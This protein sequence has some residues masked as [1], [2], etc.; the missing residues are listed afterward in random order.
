MQPAISI[1]VCH[2]DAALLSDFRTN[3]D[4]S[5]GVP[6]EL[7]V[8]DNTEN[9]YSIFG[10]YNEGVK[11][12]NGY[13][14]C[15]AHEDIAFHTQGWGHRVL[16]HFR[17]EKIGMIGVVG[18]DGFPKSPSWWWNTQFGNNHFAYLIQHWRT[19]KPKQTY[20][21]PVE[22]EPHKTVMFNNPQNALRSRVVCLD[23]LWF[24][25]RKQLFESQVRFDDDYY[26]GFHCYDTDISLQ[27]GRLKE[28]YVV[29]DIL[30]EH[31]SDANANK[32]FFDSCFLHFMKWKDKLPVSLKL[33]NDPKL[34][35]AY[36]YK[37]MLDYFYALRSCK[38]YQD[39]EIKQR[40][41]KVLFQTKPSPAIL[42]FQIL[43]WWGLLGYE[44]AR[45]PNFLIRK[46]LNPWLI[47]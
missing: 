32:E 8:I 23:G 40:I 5:I 13:I 42:E 9:R 31:F 18:G 21:Q 28:V 46:T 24:C 14:L 37:A 41:R 12:S 19:K 25:I 34:L 15:F 17:E 44:L 16:E 3:V 27:V 39:S 6:Y 47:R 10:A 20:N 2:R 7:V 38:L 1:I 26:R 30:I 43:F 22:G 4:Q 36:S 29:Y 33:G 35:K 45:Y 11:R